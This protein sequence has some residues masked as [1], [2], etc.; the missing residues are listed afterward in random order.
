MVFLSVATLI[1][2]NNDKLEFLYANPT[3]GLVQPTFS[4]SYNYYVLLHNSR[5]DYHEYLCST[6]EFIIISSISN[7]LCI[8]ITV[9]SWG[10]WFLKDSWS[11]LAHYNFVFFSI[12]HVVHCLFHIPRQV[13]MLYFKFILDLLFGGPYM[14]S[15]VTSFCFARLF[16]LACTVVC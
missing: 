12:L 5:M 9:G 13:Y 7:I 10:M 14:I 11:W 8:R 3:Y 4:T 15:T 6:S 2:L 1:F 16:T